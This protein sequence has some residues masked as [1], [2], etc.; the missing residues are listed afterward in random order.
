M[1][2]VTALILS[3]SS[4]SGPTEGE[5][6]F[7]TY[8]DLVAGFTWTT[9]IDGEV[10]EDKYELVL[11][12]KYLKLTSRSSGG[13]PAGV[14]YVG[15]D[16]ATGECNWWGFNADG[17]VSKGT[18]S[19]AKDGEWEGDFLNNG[20]TGSVK[21]KYRLTRVDAET[22]KYEILE[23]E[24][25]GQM[26]TFAIVSE[27]KSKP[28]AKAGPNYAHLKGVEGI[29]GHWKTSFE[30]VDGTA[31][32]G[33]EISEWGLNKNFIYSRGWFVDYE[34]QHVDYTITTGWDPAANKI[35]EWFAASNGGH[36]KRT[37]TW[38]PETSAWISTEVGTDVDGNPFSFN[39]EMHMPNI[40]RW[41]WKGTNF[42]GAAELPDLNITFTRVK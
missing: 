22:I 25:T 34:G 2:F 3:V 42:K 28:E 10:F 4:L 24:V 23:Q 26:E 18:M 39:V 5:K 9:T 37:G 27:W 1:H 15:V 7:Q 35:V 31:T 12:G 29:I 19:L 38:N 33:E 13:F 40:D 41:T 36:S 6:A 11:G 21:S 20:P 14:S 32:E 30:W 16:P 17:S 8:A